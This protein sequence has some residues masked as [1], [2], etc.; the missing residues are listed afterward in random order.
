MHS[1]VKQIIE[2][3][4]L[5]K[6]GNLQKCKYLIIIYTGGATSLLNFYYQVGPIKN[7]LLVC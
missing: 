2:I 7:N 5:V 6:M 3:N 4:N 1:F